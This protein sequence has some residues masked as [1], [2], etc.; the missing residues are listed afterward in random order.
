MAGRTI[1]VMG[2]TGHIRRALTE[3]LLAKRHAVRA[4]G[5]DAGKLGALSGKGAKVLSVDF[6]DPAALA[7]AF[8]MVPPS[9]GEPDFAAYQDRQSDAIAGAVRK[10]GVNKI[11]ALSSMGA[12]HPRGTGP[13]AGLHRMEQRLDRAGR[14]AVSRRFAA[15]RAG[16][17]EVRRP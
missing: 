17:P 10:A 2:A 4:L 16:R 9:Y 11:G 13:I 15:R 7:T 14:V 8:E 3:H 1:A 6:T 5:R 12:Q